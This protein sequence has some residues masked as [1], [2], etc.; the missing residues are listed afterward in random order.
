MDYQSDIFPKKEPGNNI[1]ANQ[2][3]S[4][5]AT[6]EHALLEELAKDE[7]GYDLRNWKEAGINEEEIRKRYETCEE[8]NDYRVVSASRY[9][10]W[11]LPRLKTEFNTPV[12]KVVEIIMQA[13]DKNWRKLKEHWV[14]AVKQGL[15]IY[16]MDKREKTLEY[17]RRS[18]DE[19]V[20]YCNLLNENAL[21]KE[22]FWNLAK[23]EY[24]E[25][26]QNG[27]L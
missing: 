20:R 3:V 26:K 1:S 17:P 21:A 24:Q 22:H 6:K 4:H 25:Q 14:S 13:R 7:Y 27:L 16:L 18:Y 11:I 19:Y 15:K 12:E 2:N 8:E 23:Q 5:T 10:T 9:F